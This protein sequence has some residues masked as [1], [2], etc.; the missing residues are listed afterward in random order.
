[1]PSVSDHQAGRLRGLQDLAIAD[2]RR[3]FE[4]RH[5][6]LALPPVA[7]LICAYEEEDNLGQVLAKVPA[8]ACGLEVAA[9]VVVDGGED[10]TARVAREAGAVTFV[11][12]V[13]LGH[14]VAL[15]VGSQLCLEGGAE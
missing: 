15:R 6:E 5:R 3:A 1:M 2:G 12:P 14:G 4:R 13:N 10:D 9:V 11:L 7:V 8:T